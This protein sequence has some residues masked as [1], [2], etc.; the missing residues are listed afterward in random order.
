MRRLHEAAHNHRGNGA[1]C[2]VESHRLRR[3]DRIRLR[4]NL[5][6]HVYAH[7]IGFIHRHSRR[8]AN[9]ERPCKSPREREQYSFN[10]DAYY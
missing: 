9:N 6:L 8:H 5:G 10:P 2:A 1:R 7:I 4:G 3:R